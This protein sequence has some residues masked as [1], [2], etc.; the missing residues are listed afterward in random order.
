MLAMIQ[1]WVQRKD[2]LEAEI[3]VE[4]IKV[5]MKK[6]YST[7]QIDFSSLLEVAGLSEEH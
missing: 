2:L 3:V 6:Q 5:A 4:L 1:D 7:Y